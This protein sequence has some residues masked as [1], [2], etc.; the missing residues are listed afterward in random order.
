[1]TE[2]GV[3]ATV[4]L[5]CKRF[6]AVALQ[7]LNR[8]KN[9]E[10]LAI[11]DEYDVQDLLNALVRLHFDDVRPEEP[12]PSFG[13]GASRMDFLLKREQIVVE[14]KMT[15][16]NLRDKELSN[17]LIQDVAR[18]KNH[19]DCK[20][21]VCLVYDPEALVKNPHGFESDIHKLSSE[22]LAVEAIVVP[23]R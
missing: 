19:S 5:I 3:L 8:R 1:V 9:R 16:A 10:T 18:Y 17:E 7:L 11:T 22:R 23:K 13:G 6:H 15:R 12:T 4:T 20:T 14:A 2:T 21:L